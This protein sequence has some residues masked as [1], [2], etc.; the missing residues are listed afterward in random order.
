M[1]EEKK[2]K[3]KKRKKKQ[4][5]RKKRHRSRP[6]RERHAN[7]FQSPRSCQVIG[8]DQLANEPE[9][10]KTPAASL[11]ITVIYFIIIFFF[12]LSTSK[13]QDD[14]KHESPPKRG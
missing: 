2:R 1:E 8:T 11:R 9:D 6:T 3:E 5:K 10:K 13:I 4:K 14:M 7:S 12:G